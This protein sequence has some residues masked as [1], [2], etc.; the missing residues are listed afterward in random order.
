[1]KGE[2]VLFDKSQIVSMLHERGDSQGAD[3][4]AQQLPDQVDHEKHADLLQKLG[5]N[6]QELLSRFH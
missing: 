1:M 6:P 5:I 2:P 3:Q 4:A